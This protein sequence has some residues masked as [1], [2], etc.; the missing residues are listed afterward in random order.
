MEG[1]REGVNA[2][3]SGR[4]VPS[5]KRREIFQPFITNEAVVAQKLLRACCYEG[6]SLGTLDRTRSQVAKIGRREGRDRKKFVI[7]DWIV[8]VQPYLEV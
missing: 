8:A 6:L 4:L 7:T 3:K 5:Q 1:R 2:K